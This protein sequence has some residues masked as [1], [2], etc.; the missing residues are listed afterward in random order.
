MPEHYW[1]HALQDVQALRRADD[2][3]VAAILHDLHPVDW[4]SNIHDHGAVFVRQLRQALEK[5]FPRTCKGPRKAFI[6]EQAWHLRGMRRHI[7]R[8]L[9]HRRRLSQCSDLGAA[10]KAW[11][12]DCSFRQVIA[13][14]RGWYVR[15]ALADMSDR[16]RLRNYGA[17]LRQCLR[18]DKDRFCQQIAEEAAILPASLVVKKLRC[19]GFRSKK[20]PDKVRPLAEMTDDDGTVCLTTEEVNR[21]WQRFFE[22]MEDG[23]EVAHSELLA[24]CEAKHRRDCPPVPTLDELTTLLE[25]ETALRQNQ[26]S[27]ASYFDGIPSDLGRRFPHLLARTYVHL[28]WKQ[29]LLVQEPVTFKGG[30]L[31]QAFKGKGTPSLCENYRA[32]MVSSIL[33]KANHRALRGA[34]MKSF[35]TYRLPLQIGGLAGRS[36]AQGAHCLISFAA[37]CRRTHKS[38]AVLF[39]DIKQAFYR[40]F[41]EHIVKTHV[42]DE[43][44]QRL[45]QTLQLPTSAFADFAQE[46]AEASAM[47]AA[48]ASPYVRAHVEEAMHG[49]WF[50]LLGADA[51]SQTKR[52]SRPGDNLADILFAFAFRRI[53]QKV[54]DQLAL[55]E[56]DM[57][58]ESLGVAHPYPDQLGVYPLV[59]FDALGPV[60][61]D[62]LAVL[63]ADDDAPRLMAK[64]RYVGGV[65]FDHLDR[66]GMQVNFGSGKTEIV[67]DIRGPGA[68]DIRKELYRHSP[69]VLDIPGRE[70]QVR[71][72]RL[73]AT[74]KHLGTVF[75]QRGR[76]LPEIRHRLG[77]ARQAFK[78]NRKLI[79]SNDRLPIKTRTQLFGSLVMSV[80]QFNIAIWPALTNN[81]HQAFMKGLQSV[82]SSLAYAFWGSCVFS[83]RAERIAE[84]LGLSLVDVVLRNAR[85]RYFQHIVLKADE[86]VWAFIHLDDG[87]LG[88]IRADLAWMHRQIPFAVPQE[89]PEVAWSEWEPLLRQKRRWK[90]LVARACAH[91]DGQ[92]GLRSDWHEGHRRVLDLLAELRIWKNEVTKVDTGIHVCLRCQRRFKSKSAWSVHAFRVHQRVTKAREVAQGV[93]CL[94]CHKVYALHSRLVNHLRYSSACAETIK[95]QGLTVELQPSVGSRCEQKDA[96][97]VLAPVLR[98]DGPD[99][100]VVGRLR[101]GLW[102][103]YKDRGSVELCERIFDVIEELAAHPSDTEDAVNSLWQVFQH[104]VVHPDEIPD[105]LRSCFDTYR[106]DLDMDDVEDFAIGQ[107]FDD[108]L[109]TVFSRWSWEWLTSHLDGQQETTLPATGRGELD[110]VAEFAKLLQTTIQVHPVPR[111]IKLRCLILLHLFSGRRRQQDVQEA[112]EQLGQHA[113][114][115]NYGLSVDVVISL[116]WGNLL[117]DEVREFFLLAIRDQQVVA[118]IA[119]PPCETWSRAR[120][121]FYRS[122]RGPRPVRTCES[123]WGLSCLRIKELSQVKIGSLLLFVAIQFAYVSWGYGTFMAL[124]HPSEPDSQR[125][126]SIWRLDILRFLEKQVT[127]R[128][129]RIFQGH[130]G[131][132]SPKPTD[133]MLVHPP[134]NFREIL[135]THKSTSV[136][137][138]EASIGCTAKGAFRTGRLKEYPAALCRALAQMSFAHAMARGHDRECCDPS[139][140]MGDMLESLRS[141]VGEGQ[142]GPDFC[143]AA[144]QKA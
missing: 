8:R 1:G 11:K 106:Y 140:K 87:W 42:A 38:Y 52:G 127:V 142:I 57:K 37:M 71:H 27:K 92:R 7:R 110:A 49:T 104:S 67:L 4:N 116:Q 43:A 2:D 107:R 82:Y 9:Y 68:L 89:S 16:L 36:V 80:L 135:E 13:E 99:L 121:E 56:C 17:Q 51:I 120:E 115:P 22:E 117:K 100:P 90:A 111:P 101:P 31:V 23:E 70:G 47:E 93:K 66:A 18:H 125:S 141:V 133:L 134:G 19:L 126:V 24:R 28:V 139:P 64:L 26:Y 84:A 124:E 95:Q 35:A 118:T 61:A 72:C 30:I 74:Y 6:S 12:S 29:Q 21:L 105:I 79:F 25:L 108:V 96:L 119:G 131:A 86:Y 83:W 5:Q 94:A 81:E 137:P 14:G 69:P 138:T 33:A 58:I 113:V 63:V 32:L 88:L 10:W 130:Y 77:Q 97:K 60:W 55:E 76:M 20:T 54:L 114:F 44:V 78:K 50:K 39:V 15:Q 85:L 123:P 143:A 62:D 34:S 40:L 91:E 45:F 112:F 102:I 128:R 98:A 53:L 103:D 129:W 75:S 65:L 73:V 48:A 122:Q 144:V 59:Q 132:P 3:D 109:S 136:L 41:R 46:L